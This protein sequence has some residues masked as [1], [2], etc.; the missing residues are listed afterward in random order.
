MKISGLTRVIR[1][2]YTRVRLKSDHFY[3]CRVESDIFSKPDQIRPGRT[4]REDTVKGWICIDDDSKPGPPQFDE[5]IIQGPVSKNHGSIYNCS[6]PIQ[7][8]DLQVVVI[9][10][11]GVNAIT[12]RLYAIIYLY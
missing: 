4:T 8:Q 9:T 7:S 12:E 1:I 6:K 5:D 10:T 11:N 2:K 3:F